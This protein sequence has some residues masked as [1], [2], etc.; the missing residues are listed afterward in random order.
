MDGDRLWSV[1]KVKVVRVLYS[2]PYRAGT[3]WDISRQ[4]L[5]PGTRCWSV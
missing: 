2:S 3:G 1:Q 4:I 5:N